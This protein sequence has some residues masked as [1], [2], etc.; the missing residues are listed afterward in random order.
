M[1][2]L[3]YIGYYNPFFIVNHQTF[4]TLLRYG[5]HMRQLTKRYYNRA[6]TR[7][8]SRMSK[9]GSPRAQRTALIHFDGWFL[10]ANLILLAQSTCRLNDHDTRYDK[11]VSCPSHACYIPHQS[12]TAPVFLATVWSFVPCFRIQN[13]YW[14]L[15]IP[16]C[17]YP[18]SILSVYCQHLPS[19]SETAVR[20]S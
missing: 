13:V 6:I 18:V 4:W 16:Y 14:L 19:L 2:N 11:V 9:L 5:D 15:L 1:S 10:L 12:M 7:A 3:Q 8:V 20:K 17:L